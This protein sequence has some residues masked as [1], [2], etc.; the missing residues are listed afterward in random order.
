MINDMQ[1]V[2]AERTRRSRRTDT[3][4]QLIAQVSPSDTFPNTQHEVD[5]IDAIINAMVSP[6]STDDT[7][8]LGQD[9]RTISSEEL[10]QNFRQQGGE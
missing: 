6:T 8:N 9:A 7:T 10:V 2:T 5:T 3:A 4:E 1:Q